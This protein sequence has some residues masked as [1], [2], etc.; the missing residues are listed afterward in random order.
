MSDENK[1]NEGSKAT[2]EHQAVDVNEVLKRVEQLEST[3]KRLLD[4]SKNWKNQATDFK[5]KLE[6]TEKTK[7][8][9][10]GDEKAQLEYEKK[11]REK[12]EN[13]N[14]KLKSKTLDQAIRSKV[15]GIAKNVHSLDDFMNQPQFTHFLKAGI[16]PDALTIDDDAVKNY[17]NA[18]SEAKPFLLKNTQQAGVDTSRP[19]PDDLPSL[20]DLENVKKGEHKENIKA[21]LSKW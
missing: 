21:A 10:S 6:E 8:A 2:G 14:K 18:V 4:E 9:Q 20:K 7:I 15:S 11:Q 12:V 17:V 3:N 16:D 13:E 1:G 5:S 19:K